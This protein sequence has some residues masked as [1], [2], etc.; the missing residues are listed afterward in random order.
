[1]ATKN[2]DS[3]EKFSLGGASGVRAYPT[4]E[5]TGDEGWLTQIELRYSMGSTIPY[6]FYD[7]GAIR[8]S[9]FAPTNSTT[10][11][12]DLSGAG[13]GIRYQ[14]EQWSLDATVA[15]RAR[16][17]KAQSDPSRDASPTAWVSLGYRF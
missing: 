7:H 9:T 5:G 6:A 12:R 1:M 3:S 10:N 4:G 14:R 8:T 15:W 13:M 2:L 16:G 17:G 11:R